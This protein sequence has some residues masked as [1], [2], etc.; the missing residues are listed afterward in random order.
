MA[1]ISGPPSASSS[2]A[3]QRSRI[4]LI[5]LGVIVVILLGAILVVLVQDDGDDDGEV[6]TAGPSVTSSAPATTTAGSVPGP[7]CSADA[8]LDAV[9]A[10]GE[11]GFGI[12]AEGSEVV[13]F[14]CTPTSAGDFAGGYAWARLMAPDLDP[15]IVFFT[16]YAG[17][18]PD[19]GA[20]FSDWQVLFYGS[21]VA[22]E[23]QIPAA[24]CDLLPGAP[25]R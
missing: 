14:E 11:A 20:T 9:H 7:E 22:C 17:N 18:E 5:V 2:P 1:E 4:L 10:E 21:D 13:E 12:A 23:D 15:L 16:A 8:L 25:R 24:A 3:G 19:G 6:S